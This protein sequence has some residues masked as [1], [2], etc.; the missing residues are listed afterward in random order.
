MNKII[1]SFVYLLV[2]LLLFT[3]LNAFSCDSNLEKGNDSLCII[4]EYEIKDT[5]TDSTYLKNMFT[6][7]YGNAYQLE[8]GIVYKGKVKVYIADIDSNIICK[9]IDSE[10]DKG[11]YLFELIPLLFNSD[12]FSSDVYRILFY[13]YPNNI[14]QM[15][16]K[17]TAFYLF[18]KKYNPNSE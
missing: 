13:Y 3:E 17:D 2:S 18:K 4:S 6:T 5:E 15:I 11:K 8:F 10:F 14:N 9:I 12:K 7:V 16:M 1:F